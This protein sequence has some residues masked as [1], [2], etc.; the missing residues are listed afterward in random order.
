MGIEH[1][2]NEQRR[3]PSA[4]LQGTLPDHLLVRIQPQPNLVKRIKKKKNI[5]KKY[6]L[7]PEWNNVRL[8]EHPLPY[9]SLLLK[10]N[11]KQNK[12]TCRQVLKEMI[13]QEISSALKVQTYLHK[14]SNISP[15]DSTARFLVTVL[16]L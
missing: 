15:R 11:E 16:Q 10:N 13:A 4:A 5:I 9:K 7:I 2:R 8:G 1:T 14:S 3:V 12:I 6:F